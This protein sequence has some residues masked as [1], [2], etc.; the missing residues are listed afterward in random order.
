LLGYRGAVGV[1]EQADFG[2]AV[3]ELRFEIGARGGGFGNGSLLRENRIEMAG[4]SVQ[5]RNKIFEGDI[6]GKR[7]K[8][9]GKISTQRAQR[10]EAPRSQR[11]RAVEEGSR[12]AK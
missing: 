1:E 2:L 10:Q 9:K 11:R 7:K 6:N 3:A 8:E 5:E 12:L 4:K